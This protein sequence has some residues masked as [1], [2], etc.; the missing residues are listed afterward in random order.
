MGIFKTEKKMTPHEIEEI[1]RESRENPTTRNGK[2]GRTNMYKGRGPTER[3]RTFLRRRLCKYVDSGIY[4][5]KRIIELLYE[6]FPR[7]KDKSSVGVRVSELCNC[8]TA[9]S[10]TKPCGGQ[11]RGKVAHKRHDDVMEW[12]KKTIQTWMR[13]D[14][15]NPRNSFK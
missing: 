4:T 2:S 7:Y 15:V 11:Y 5:R 10:I 12:D 14:N 1:V 6:E 8:T 13:N 3:D 9:E